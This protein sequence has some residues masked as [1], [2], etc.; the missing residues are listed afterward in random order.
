MSQPPCVR[1][2]GRPDLLPNTEVFGPY[3]GSKTL[4]TTY[5]TLPGRPKGYSFNGNVTASISVG[6]E[7]TTGRPK[8][9]AGARGATSQTFTLT[10]ATGTDW[11]SSVTNGGSYSRATPLLSASGG[12]FNALAS[13]TTK[14]GTKTLGQFTAQYDTSRG[15][16]TGQDSGSAG[17]MP[18]GSWTKVLNLGDGINAATATYDGFGQLLG[19]GTPAWQ[20]VAGTVSLPTRDLSWTYDLAGNRK[21]ESEAGGAV[22]TYSTAA[23]NPNADG[24]LNQYESITGTRAEPGIAY[25]ADGNLT[26]DSVWTYSY[27]EENRLKTLTRNTPQGVQ[28]ITMAYDYL[29]RRIRKSVTG[30]GTYDIKFL[31]SGWKLAAEL[32][33]DGSTVNKVFVWGRDFSDAQGNAGGAGSLLA[34]IAGTTISYAVPDAYGSI[35][36]Y[37]TSAN[38][39]NLVAAMEY[40]PYG[41]GVNGHGAVT[42]YPIGFSGQYMDWEPGLVYYGLRYYAPKHGRFINR[43]PIEEAGGNNLYGFVGNSPYRGWDVLGLSYEP[44]ILTYEWVCSGP[45]SHDYYISQKCVAVPV[46]QGTRA[47]LYVVRADRIFDWIGNYMQHRLG[48]SWNLGSPGGSAASSSSSAGSSSGGGGGPAVAPNKTP[49]GEARAALTAAQNSRG[50]YTGQGA[51]GWDRG[52]TWSNDD[53]GFG[54]TVFTNSETGQAMLAFRGTDGFSGPDW[55]AN[56]GQWAGRDT[57][58][59][60]QAV[61]VARDFSRTY[62]SNASIAGH[63]LG[64]GLASLGGLVTGLNTYTFNASGLSPSIMS[65]NSVSASMGGGIQAYYVAGEILSTAQD[66]SGRYPAVGNRIGLAP[67]LSASNI[68]IGAA[69]PAALSVKLHFINSVISS[70]EKKVAAACGGK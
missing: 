3:Y 60:E 62:G 19:T 49:C 65:R 15:W 58:Q 66:L 42:D 22:T 67:S 44:A 7:A 51:P 48:D 36:G 61:S 52:Q 33:A 23:T 21:T 32:A 4:T 64:G 68:L 24:R 69:S 20:N 28:T 57:P 56:G 31:W 30:T 1:A 2:T 16:R 5:D 59:Y 70:L 40:S 63:S 17:G 45:Y 8:T 6:F 37:I 26:Q 18:A 41:K 55:A 38:G 43:D 14:W 11:V 46:Y 25:D 39:G 12:K 29:G 10:Y 34:Q 54:A 50:A 9:I 13:V 53:T 27:D 35:V 47:E